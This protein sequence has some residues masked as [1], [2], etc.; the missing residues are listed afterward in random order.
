MTLRVKKMRVERILNTQFLAEKNS[1]QQPR[2]QQGA[3]AQKIIIN[4]LRKAFGRKFKLI[5]TAPP[6]SKA[7]DL[8]AKIEDTTIQFEIKSRPQKQSPIVFHEKSLGRNEN[9][10]ILDNIARIY[11]DGRVKTFT[12]LVDL[13]RTKEDRKYGFPGDEGV[14]KSGSIWIK[15]TDR[16]HLSKIR[17]YLID[18]IKEENHYLAVFT[19]SDNTVS[20]FFTGK[21]PNILKAKRIPN[22]NQIVVDTYGSNYKHR[23][24]VAVKVSLSS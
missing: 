20:Y 18:T 9:D 17:K 16:T 21:T 15:I 1:N 2:V 19:K 24:R 6:A 11:T 8:V 3:A 14:A 23:M 13:I 12:D 4:D 7:P 5:S 10:K 22:F